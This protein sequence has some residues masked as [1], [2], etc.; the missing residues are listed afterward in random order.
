MLELHLLAIMFVALRMRNI[1]EVI[2]VG[3]KQAYLQAVRAPSVAAT[4]HR[5]R[6]FSPSLSVGKFAG[7]VVQQDVPSHFA[8]SGLSDNPV[9]ERQLLTM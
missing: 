9:H 8:A 4:E 2:G 5:S 6:T 3:R 1:L 7:F